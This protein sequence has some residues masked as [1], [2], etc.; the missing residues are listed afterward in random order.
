[1]QMGS[2]LAHINLHDDFFWSADCQ[3]FA[4]GSLKDG[5]RWGS[6]KGASK[7]VSDGMV[8]SIFDT[9][10]SA[11]IIPKAYFKNFLKELFKKV[12]DKAEYEVDSGYVITRCYTNFPT[13]YFM[14]DGVWLQI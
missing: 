10:A 2:Y 6:I 8:Y 7:T 3:G 5:Y 4:I 9:G 11:I 12:I 14:F 13:L 1:M